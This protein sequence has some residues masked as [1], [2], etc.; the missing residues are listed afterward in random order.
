MSLERSVIWRR[1]DVPGMDAGQF[2]SGTAGWRIGGTAIFVE[3]GSIAKLAYELTCDADWSTRSFSVSGW[4]GERQLALHLE[5]SDSAGW[6]TSD[7][8]PSA[9]SD[10]GLS[11]VTSEAL[12]P[13]HGSVDWQHLVDVDLGF[14]PATNTNAIRRLDLKPGQEA[15]TTALWLDT[16]DWMLKP[17]P[18]V[19][20]RKTE[21]LLAY[22]SPLHDFRADL[23]SDSFGVIENYPGLW[24]AMR[25][26]AYDSRKPCSAA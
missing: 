24:A 7:A 8:G 19:Y 1:L 2:R 17:L 12:P 20:R 16:S 6:R 3:D 9:V 15:E 5:R 26:E 4:V 23:T 21:T 11:A 14:T 10:A 22:E 25:I 18:Q 13:S